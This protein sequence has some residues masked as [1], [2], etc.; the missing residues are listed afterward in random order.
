MY[1]GRGSRG[2][3]GFLRGRG[4]GPRSS[5]WRGRGSTRNTVTEQPPKTIDHDAPLGRLV[6][7]ITFDTIS[8]HGV[9]KEDAKITG[10]K[11]AASYSLVDSSTPK[12]IIPGEPAVWKPPQLPSQPPSDHGDYLRDYNGARFPENPI[13]P[14]VQ[15]LFALNE[16]FDSSSIDIV[17]CASSLGDILRFVRSIESTFRFDVEMVGNTLFL[18]RNQRDQVIPDVRGYGHSFLDNFTSYQPEVRE[19]KS[20][21]RVVSYSFGGLK[22]LVR[23]EC[24]GYFGDK[25]TDVTST[26]NEH[27][28]PNIKQTTQSHSI[29]TKTSGIIVPQQSVLEIKTRSQV[30]PIDMNDHLPRLWV[31]QIPNFIAAYHNRGNFEDVQEKAVQQDLIN[32]EAEHQYELRKFASILHQLIVEVKR[33]GHLKLELCRTGLGSLELRE[34]AG[35][36]RE[37]LPGDWKDLWAKHLQKPGKDGEG[38]LITD[39]DSDSDSSD[40]GYPNL[41]GRSSESENSDDDDR[42]SVDYTACDA[43][44]GYCGNCAQR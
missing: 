29:A 33:A 36:P 41:K 11:Y 20:H 7:E 21:Q 18:I 44:C 15:S 31:R 3:Q 25:T 30:R 27:K 13:L 22:C 6:T 10:C 26:A 43:L 38:R 19:T 16:E 28:T 39:F 2:S 24:D 1:R 42:Y 8:V 5:N 9:E 34:Q 12:I 14:T 4:R 23:F 37:V 35:K 17:G 40:G 32:W